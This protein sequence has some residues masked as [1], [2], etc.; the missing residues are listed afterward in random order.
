[1]IQNLQSAG[2]TLIIAYLADPG[3]AMVDKHKFVK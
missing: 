3:K 2:T 1:M